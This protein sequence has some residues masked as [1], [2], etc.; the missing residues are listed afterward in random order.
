MNIKNG[1]DKAY[2]QSLNTLHLNVNI[3]ATIFTISYVTEV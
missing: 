2:T 1:D 3:R